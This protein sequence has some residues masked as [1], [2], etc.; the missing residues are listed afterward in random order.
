MVRVLFVCHG[1]ICRSP[2]AEFVMK[3]KAAE[4]DVLCEVAS[5]ATSYEEVGNPVYYAI[6]PYL[7]KEGADYKSKRA[8]R[9]EKADGDYYDYIL[10]MDDE[11]IAAAE[12][13]VGEKNSAKIHKLMDYTAAPGDIP[14]PWYT[15]DFDAAYEAILRGVDGFIGYLKKKRT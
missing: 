10:C 4:S 12:R 6:V 1:N 11:N 3:R 5:R 15:R 9:L 13:I 7:E 8:K 14:D 2:L